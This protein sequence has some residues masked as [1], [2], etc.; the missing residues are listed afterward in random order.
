MNEVEKNARRARRLLLWYPTAWR[1]R[2]GVEFVDLMEQEFLEIP[3]SFKRASNIAYKRS[4]VRLREL[5]LASSTLNPEDQP[6]AAI[7]TA[8]VISTIFTALALSFWSV[9]MLNWNENWKEPASTAT[10]VWTACTTVIAGFVVGLVVALLCALLWSA[11]KRSVKGRQSGMVAPLSLIATCVIFLGFSIRGTLRFVIARGGIDW[12]RPG[13]AIKQLA[14]A[15]HVLSSN[16]LWI[17]MSPR[18]SLTVRSNIVYGLIPVALLVLSLSMSVLVRRTDFSV[19]RVRH[20][21]FVLRLLAPAMALF[22]VAYFGLIASGSQVL[23]AAFGQPLSYPPLIIEFGVMTV[24]AA[25]E[26]VTV[27][28]LVKNTPS[29]RIDVA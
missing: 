21:R 14:G 24:M 4:V 23:G 9:A 12:I 5:G 19:T 20:G 29:L 25:L 6:R 22:I 17:W 3:H 7:A 8:V 15:T 16:I 11:C 18:E 28:Q 27:R 26:I 13:Q 10:T 1:E 2:Y